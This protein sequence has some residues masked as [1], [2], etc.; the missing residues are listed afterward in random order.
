VPEALGIK[1]FDRPH[2]TLSATSNILNC[3][4]SLV[5][6]QVLVLTPGRLADS[7]SATKPSSIPTPKLSANPS[8]IDLA[9]FAALD[10]E[11]MAEVE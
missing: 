2:H 9:A 4:L 10:A 5:E 6:N 3:L 8:A 11:A 1:V 7:A